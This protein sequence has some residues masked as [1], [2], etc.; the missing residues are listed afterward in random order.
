MPN[1]APAALP[2]P[3][4]DDPSFDAAVIVVQTRVLD[5]GPDVKAAWKRLNIAPKQGDDA[6]LAALFVPEVLDFGGSGTRERY[7]GWLVSKL[8]GSAV[9]ATTLAKALASKKLPD[10]ARKVILQTI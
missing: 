7:F 10:E 1:R 6:R 9:G 3:A 5:E 8:A 4:S 2:R